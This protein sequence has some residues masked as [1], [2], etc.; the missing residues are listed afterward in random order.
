MM[1]AITTTHAI[2]QSLPS[3]N[4]FSKETAIRCRYCLE[5][6]GMAHDRKSREGLRAA[7]KCTEKTLVKKPAA[8]IPF[9]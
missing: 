7:H 5:V 6:L 1:P 3:G 9:N 2:P 8:S 4:I